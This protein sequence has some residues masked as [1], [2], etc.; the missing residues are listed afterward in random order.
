M[1]SLITK[2]ESQLRATVEFGMH[3]DEQ[4][5]LL[6]CNYRDTVKFPCISPEQPSRTVALVQRR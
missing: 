1:G 5:L 6:D 4:L 2:G 3:C